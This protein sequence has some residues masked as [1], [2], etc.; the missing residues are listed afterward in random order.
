MTSGLV[1]TVL[2]R[3]RFAAR[4]AFWRALSEHGTGVQ[5]LSLLGRPLIDRRRLSLH[6]GAGSLRGESATGESRPAAPARRSHR[7][8]GKPQGTVQRIATYI[9]DRDSVGKGR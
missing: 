1:A 6:R 5:S 8:L 7:R 3:K 9:W 4:D 2:T